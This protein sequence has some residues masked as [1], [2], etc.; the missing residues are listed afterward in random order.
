[1][2]SWTPGDRSSLTLLDGGALVTQAKLRG[3]V[4]KLMVSLQKQLRQL[5]FGAHLPDMLKVVAKHEQ[6]NNDDVGFSAFSD[7]R[8]LLIDALIANNQQSTPNLCFLSLYFL[9]HLFCS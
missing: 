3:M 2:F 7:H 6:R 4:N 1:V 9:F 5:I 8:G